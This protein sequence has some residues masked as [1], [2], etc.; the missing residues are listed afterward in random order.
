MN[1]SHPGWFE[2]IRRQYRYLRSTN[3]HQGLTL[4]QYELLVEGQVNYREARL[5]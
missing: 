3:Q 5:A 4:A 2:E 1:R